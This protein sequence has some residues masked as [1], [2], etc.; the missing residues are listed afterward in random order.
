MK[1]THFA[2]LFIF[3][4]LSAYAQQWKPYKIDDSV[5]VSL[6]EKFTSKDTLGQQIINS[7]AGFGII[8]ITIS[9]DNP[10]TTPDIEKERHLKKYYD[11]FV[12]RI[13]SS[14]GGGTVSEARDTV[15]GKLKAKNFTMV[16]D[17][18]SGKQ[19]R[20]FLILHENGN[21]YT[22]Q[23]LYKDIHTEYALPE[24]KTFFSSIRIPPDADIKTQFTSPGTTT[25]H[26]PSANRN[27]LLAGGAAAIL[28]V[29]AIILVRRRRRKEL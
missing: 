3:I 19:F 7:T 25:G 17:D 8:Q 6:P 21:T 14:S 2:I 26:S 12:K 9:P 16:V 23:Y 18:A 11:N 1:K 10:K 15:I 5:Q 29:L 20:N 24:N 27:N 4:C 22:F 28:I 13:R